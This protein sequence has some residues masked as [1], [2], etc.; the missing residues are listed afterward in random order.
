MSSSRNHLLIDPDYFY[1]VRK[2]P[3]N[4]RLKSKA[5]MKKETMLRNKFLKDSIKI[6]KYLYIINKYIVNIKTNKFHFL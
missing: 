6:N 1:K 5:L 4:T 2:L 3:I